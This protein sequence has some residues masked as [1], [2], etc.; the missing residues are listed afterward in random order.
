MAKSHKIQ[1]IPRGRVTAGVGTR[2]GAMVPTSEVIDVINR[3]QFD[4]CW[5]GVMLVG[6]K[7]RV[8]AKIGLYG[9]YNIAPH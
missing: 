3:S 2:G 1:C 7:G 6:V 9:S 8:S 4:L 5:Y